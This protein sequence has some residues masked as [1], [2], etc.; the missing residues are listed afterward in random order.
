MPFP[1]EP[2]QETDWCW[3][4]VT[5]SVEQYFDS[6]STLTQCEIANRMLGRDCCNDPDSCNLAFKLQDV[7]RPLGRLA[8]SMVG[9]PPFTD[10]KKELTANRP[11]AVRIGWFGGGAHFV[12]ICGYK[13]LPSG[14]RILQIADPFYG[15]L[16]DGEYFGIWEIDYDLFP[17]SYQQ[18]GDWTATFFLKPKPGDQ[19]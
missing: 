6:K 8:D 11:I 2:Q 9:Y 4:A 19:R 10:L 14:A 15:N 12:V 18:G 3:A 5:D 1:I 7:L 13:V 17:E 16:V